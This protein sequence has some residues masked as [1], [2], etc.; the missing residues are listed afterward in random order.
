MIRLTKDVVL[1]QIVHADL[2]KVEEELSSLTG[3][4]FSEAMTIALL[5]SVYRAHL[6]EPCARD[7][8]RQKMA[9][10]DFMTPKEFEKAWDESPAE[11]K[12][13]KRT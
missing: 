2:L 6:S 1:P 9:N 7:T 10:A 5:I 13:Y 8:F 3:K 12:K 11:P 4:P